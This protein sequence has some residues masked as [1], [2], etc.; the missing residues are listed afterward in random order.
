[1]QE[2]INGCEKKKILRKQKRCDYRQENDGWYFVTSKQRL[3]QVRQM[4]CC[5]FFILRTNEFKKFTERLTY[6]SSTKTLSE[7]CQTK[8][9]P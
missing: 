2:W 5:Y 8:S 6:L 1:M 9:K 4:R 3:S 7:N